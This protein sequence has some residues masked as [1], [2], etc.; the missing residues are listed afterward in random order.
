LVQKAAGYSLHAYAT[1]IAAERR[2]KDPDYFILCGLYERALAEASRRQFTGE[3]DAERALQM[4]CA[5]YIDFV[6]S[7]GQSVQFWGRATRGVPGSGEVWARYIRF[8]VSSMN[9]C[10]LQHVYSFACVRNRN[11]SPR[12]VR[13]KWT[14][15]TM[16]MLEVR[17]CDTS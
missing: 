15:M 4:W 9:L 8:L 2:R 5:G 10:P 3:V 13:L 6:K 11:K 16:K 17:D 14:K 1:Y 12:P 7:Q